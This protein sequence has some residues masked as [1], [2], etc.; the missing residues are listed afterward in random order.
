M[1]VARRMPLAAGAYRGGQAFFMKIAQCLNPR[2]VFTASQQ[3]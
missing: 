2:D 1:S 3:F